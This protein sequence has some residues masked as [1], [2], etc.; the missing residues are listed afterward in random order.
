MIHSLP[1]VDSA[2][3]VPF[4]VNAGGVDAS[5]TDVDPAAFWNVPSLMNHQLHNVAL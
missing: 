5:R 2:R 3:V 1:A 4:G